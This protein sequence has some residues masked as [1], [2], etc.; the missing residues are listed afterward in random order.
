MRCCY[1]AFQPL[2]NLR[3]STAG[4]C[5]R[6][7]RRTVPYNAPDRI[8]LLNPDPYIVFN[9]FCLLSRCTCHVVHSIWIG[10]AKSFGTKSPESLP[11]EVL[12]VKS[13]CSHRVA[14]YL[15]YPIL[16]LNLTKPVSLSNIHGTR[17]MVVD[18]K[19]AFQLLSTHC[20]PPE[21]VLFHPL[22]PSAVTFIVS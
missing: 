13:T 18:V 4:F 19:S 10:K 3:R 8:V 12:G 21:N 16:L 9:K 7:V 22:G 6:V 1:G 2:E 11:M 14:S 17:A 5:D 15:L 20:S